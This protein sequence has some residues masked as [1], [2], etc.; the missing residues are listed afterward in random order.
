[1]P[2]TKNLEAFY[3]HKFDNPP[4]LPPVGAGDFN[5]FSL[6]DSTGGTPPAPYA[7]YDFYKI[8]LIRGKHRCHYA[9]KSIALHG[10]TLLFF[11]PTVPYRFERLADDA[12]G[13]FCV[14]KESFFT[15]NH[16]NGIHDLPVFVPGGNPVYDL[17][18]RQDKEVA[19]LFEK[20]RDEARSDYRFKYD[21]LRNLVFEL[22]HY[23][24]KTEPNEQLYHHPDTNA[25]ITSI[26]TELLEKQFPIESREQCVSMRSASDFAERLS[27]HV[28]HL[29][30]AVRLTTGKTT[31]THITE[32]L[33]AEAIALLNTRTGMYPRLVIAWGL[34]NPLTLPIFLKST[35]T[36]RLLPS[37][38]F[39]FR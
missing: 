20:I 13:F 21:L 9:D 6:A 19:A 35:P 30:R 7:R 14:F 32:R 5:V 26:F 8:M 38:L 4:S 39:E 27:V 3:T 10:N 24:M 12:T 16:R 28:N 11:N 15:E 36:L 1:M 31:T 22:I 2:V 18:E 34:H 17:N 29:N 37:D 33:V 25:R 23:A